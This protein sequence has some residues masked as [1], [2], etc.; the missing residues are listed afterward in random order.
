APEQIRGERVDARADIYALGCVLYY[1]LTGVVPFP[2]ESDEAK[3]WAQLSDP[4]PKP[5]ARGAPEA[6]DAVVERALAK[7]P[8]DRYPPAGDLG[9][10]ALAA[11]SGELPAERERRVATGAAAPIEVETVSAVRPEAV[12]LSAETVAAEESRTHVQRARRPVLLGIA[13]ATAAGVGV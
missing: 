4:P 8:E 1:T 9:R 11:A 6:F 13:L 7:Y 2:R 10:A 5:S 12:P 3:L